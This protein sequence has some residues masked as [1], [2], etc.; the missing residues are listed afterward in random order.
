MGS[1]S[2]SGALPG[3]LAGALAKISGFAMT[4]KSNP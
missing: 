1:G 4:G 2:V 3:L